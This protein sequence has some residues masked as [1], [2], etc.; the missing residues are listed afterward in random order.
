MMREAGVAAG[1]AGHRP[2][3]HAWIRDHLDVDFQMCSHYNP[4][5]RSDHAEHISEGE[6]WEDEDREKML[7]VIATIEKPVVHYK[8]F[9]A[10]NKPILSAF[11]VLRRGM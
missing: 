6:V 2:D 10:G 7:R 11:E 9:A 4:T 1:F 3:S 8:V 5:D